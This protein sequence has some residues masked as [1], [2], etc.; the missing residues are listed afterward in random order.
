MLSA[1]T[2]KNILK[3]LAHERHASMWQSETDTGL[4]NPVCNQ[5]PSAEIH[6]RDAPAPQTEWNL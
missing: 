3:S 1:Q 6:I 5:I 2:L 4:I